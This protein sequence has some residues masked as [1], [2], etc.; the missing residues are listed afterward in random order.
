MKTRPTRLFVRALGVALLPALSAAHA[1]DVVF[2]EANEEAQINTGY[3]P[4]LNGGYVNRNELTSGGVSV[5]DFNADG[6]MDMYLP[7]GG[8]GP[9]QLLI[10][11]GDGTFVD[12][13][14]QWGINDW[15]FAM[16]S[17]VGDINK[18]GY[19]D[20]YVVSYGEAGAEPYSGACRMY[21]N[22]GPDNEGKFRFED[23]AVEA[24]V[25]HVL[26]VFIEGTGATFGDVDLD[27]NVDLV[28]TCWSLQEYGTRIYINQGDNT[29]VDISYDAIPDTGMMR[30]FTPKLIDL[31]G[32]IYPELLL[33]NDFHESRLY[34]N[35]GPGEN[36]ELTFREVTDPAGITADCNGMG[37]TVADFNGDGLLDWYMTNI[38]T[39]TADCGNTL[40]MHTG[41]DETGMPIFED[42]AEIAGVRDSG[43]GW[44]TTSGDFDNDG[45]FDLTMTNGY[46]LWPLVPTR[47]FLNDGNGNFTDAAAA[48]G[49]TELIKGH[50]MAHLDYDNDGDLDFVIVEGTGP[51]RFFRNDTVN[52]NHWLR[53]NL[54]T[55]NHPCLAPM[56]LGTRI[57]AYAG[58][59]VQTQTLASPTTY[60][61]QSE[62]IMHLG[63]ADHEVIDRIDFEWADGRVTTLTDVPTNQ[64]LD[65]EVF[66]PADLL[67]DGTIDI[68][69]VFTM[70]EL[71]NTQDPGADF[72]GDGIVDIDDI[73]RFVS[74]MAN[75]C[76]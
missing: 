18:D 11:Q 39:T 75:R 38:Y 55:R 46:S 53:L 15:L 27:G 69:D 64:I 30:C 26:P 35:N 8:T 3:Y 73:T 10:N 14:A 28:V 25:N 65:V 4:D 12:E 32:D 17:A 41:N 50:G 57:T 43:W 23:I 68:F 29:F 31:N 70:L 42:R 52:N 33:T 7:R 9:D 1:Q 51:T 67:R 48:A 60:L 6:W 61:G 72:T 20:L 45:D 40:F 36:G 21:L 66:H 13:A 71:Y 5:G 22:M 16:G 62:T 54:V 19:Q 49:L 74:E 63:F 44:G 34:V 59:S 58:D 24:G 47:M 76:D 37:A 2:T 56:G